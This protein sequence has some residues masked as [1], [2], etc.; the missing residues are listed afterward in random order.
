MVK[1]RKMIKCRKCT[2]QFV[3]NTHL[4]RH[5]ALVHMKEDKYQCKECRQRFA[6]AI[7]LKKH[8]KTHLTCEACNKNFISLF[9]LNAHRRLHDNE[10]EC[11]TCQQ[12]FL[13]IKEFEKHVASHKRQEFNKTKKEKEKKKMDKP[14]S[15]RSAKCFNCDQVFE[16]RVLLNR[17]LKSECDHLSIPNLLFLMDTD[18]FDVEFTEAMHGCMTE[19]KFN[20]KNLINSEVKYLDLME[21]NIS[22]ALTFLNQEK[23]QVKWGY[24]MEVRFCRTNADGEMEYKTGL[25][26][27]KDHAYSNI[28]ITEVDEQ[29]AEIRSDMIQRI[30][31]YQKEGSKWVLCEIPSF[32]LQFYRVQLNRGGAPVKLPSELKNKKA[33]INLETDQCFKWSIISALHH[34]EVVHSERVAEYQQWEND[35]VWPVGDVVTARDVIEF[36]KRTKVA[37]YTHFWGP[38]GLL[39]CTFR[40][41]RTIAVEGPRVHILLYDDHWMAITNLSALYKTNPTNSIIICDCCLATF[42]IRKRYDDHLPC[43]PSTYI[44][45]EVMPI[46]PILQFKDFNKCVDLADIVYADIEAILRRSH[47]AGKIQKH[48]PCCAGAYWVS[49]VDGNEYKEFSGEKCMEE[50][51]KY[52]DVLARYIYNRNRT[53]TR[54]PAERTAEEME[55]HE[56]ATQCMW[57][58]REFIMHNP[59]LQK[60]FDHDH[61]TGRYRG[62]ACQACNNKLR[63][64]RNTLVVAFHNFRGYDSHALCLEGLS[65]MPKWDLRPIAQNPEK[66]MSISAYLR[67]DEMNPMSRFKVK[68]IDTLQLMNSSLATLAQNM[69]KNNNYQLM[70]H[71]MAMRDTYP[72]ITQADIAAKGIFPYS[73]IDSWAKLDEIQLPPLDDFYDELE[74]KISTS[75]V[76]YD[77]AQSMFQQFGCQTIFDYQLRYLELDCRLLA[78]VFEEF[79]R[80]TKKEDGFDAAHFITVSQLSYA[81]AL[82]KCNTKIGLIKQ[83]EIFRDVERCKRGGYAFVNKHLCKA[84]NPYV[85]P[86]Q[87]HSKKDVYLGDVDANNLYG[88]A[89]RYPLPVGDFKYM[90][91][92]D[93]QLIDWYSVRVDGDVGY[94][95][96]CDLLYP[97]DIHDKTQ[98]LPLA[99]EVAQITQDMLPEY[100]RKL[101]S[102]KNLS[103]QPLSTNPDRYRTCTKLLAT[104][105]DKKEYVVHFAVLQTYLRHG[106]IIDKIHRVI[107]FRQEPIF[108]EYIDY[109]TKRR[110]E[111]LNDF[112]KDFYKQKNCSLFGKSLENK[113]NRCDIVLCNSLGKFVRATSEH[114]F[115]SARIFKETL[116]A[117]ELTKVNV[118][119]DSPIAIGAAVLDISKDIMYRLAYDE[120][121]KYE[122][123]FDCKINIVGGDTDSFFLEVIGID[124][125]W[126]LYRQMMEDGLLDT[127][128]YPELHQMYSDAH[129][130]EL[131][132]IKDE[133]KGHPFSEFVLLRPKSYSMKAL[134]MVGED[135][136]KSKGVSRRKVKGFTHEDYQR[137]FYTEIE[138]SVNCRRMQSM[139]HVMYNIDQ[140]KVALS[141]ADDKRAWLSNNFSLP[142]G[143]YRIPFY[144]QHPPPDADDNIRKRSLDELYDEIFPPKR[145]RL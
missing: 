83:P 71:S 135:K 10:H 45:H 99:P 117:A 134:D 42:H 132:C 21:P 66:Y 144:E 84:N 67:V 136:R 73:Y 64:D 63:Q 20:S 19:Y 37:V 16:N 107:Q 140:V 14:P 68:F 61:L 2:K 32:T 116:V 111:A 100:F 91:E 22:L 112:E 24:K 17:H 29:L 18:A 89:L 33:V 78:D 87:Q 133:F 110:Q 28:D 70:R 25:F 40:P 51:C 108:R 12:K 15:P 82:K 121:P 59:L 74:E 50:L 1:I 11:G 138:K 49:R 131:G 143:H 35:Y 115:K 3:D 114:R 98:Y 76:E 7:E 47:E 38:K 36:V 39:E 93:F 57:C 31:K 55:R 139:Q 125:I 69:C 120:F 54:V 142:Y 85:N 41:P 109:N 106:L 8:F 101:V 123:M 65:N 96:V 103:R 6:T 60:V 77:R 62:P 81:S 30:E 102:R 118:E 75:Q 27:T 137:V 129:K 79:R 95:V 46:D 141:H 119:L 72:N 104:C 122:Q 43:V 86:C 4:K 9:K 5:E 44:Q 105:M 124:M 80:L 126:V 23:V 94:F 48:V 13:Y 127:S 130:A 90:E 145:Q 113:R 92:A 58:K 56:A 88:N 26:A 34:T 52:I 97:Q 128:N 53:A